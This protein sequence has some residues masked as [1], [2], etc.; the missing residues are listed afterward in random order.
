MLKKSQKGRV[1]LKLFIIILL[2]MVLSCIIFFFSY[3]KDNRFTAPGP[4]GQYGV[5]IVSQ[6]DLKNNS[7]F[8]LTS[9]WEIYRDKLLT[10]EDFSS[11]L[12]LADEYIFIGQYGG[13]E[14]NNPQSNSPSPH[15]K[16][17][18]RLHIN[19]PEETHNYILKLPE[20]F[21][22]Y[23]LYIDG[24]L[25]ME[26]GDPDPET[27][28]PKTGNTKVTFSASGLTEL[29]MAVSDYSHFY[30]GMI[31]PPA[32]GISQSVDHLIDMRFFIRTI[33]LTISLVVGIVYFCVWILLKR[34]KS[35]SQ[36]LSFYYSL[37]C[38]CY[39][40]F[41]A[42]PIVK[43][44]YSGG[45]SWYTIERFSFP[46][47]LLLII[48][49]QSKLS[50]IKASI[51][52]FMVCL[53]AITCLWAICIPMNSNSSLSI[54]L[55][56][57]IWLTIYSCLTA[58]FLFTSSC[59]CAYKGSAYS[60]SMLS[61][62]VVFAVA[63]V[64]E[65]IF[66]LFEPIYIGW[67]SEISGGAMVFSMG[68]I[69][70]SEVSSQF[71]RKLNLEYEVDFI[72]RQLDFQ[73]K[74][75]ESITQDTQAVK[76]MRHDLRH[77]LV[78]LGQLANAADSSGIKQYIESLSSNLSATQYKDY[79]K[80]RTVNAIVAHYL[81]LAES[82]GITTEAKLN[83]PESIGIVSSMDLCIILGN[84]LENAIEACRKVENSYKFIRVASRI[85]EDTISIVVTNSFDGQWS[86]TSGSYL[87]RKKSWKEK[88]IGLSSANAICKKY[89]GL[90][91]YNI[92]EGVWKACALVHM[93]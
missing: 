40:L 57:S 90:T 73:R 88:G 1:S 6:E 45:M 22:A 41:I 49:I 33:T 68:A 53:S 76:S 63:L 65:R 28:T 66:P 80:N 91:T 12:Y 37:L 47:M 62:A 8:F 52:N 59:Y 36:I 64:M 87:S 51:T 55:A 89:R 2:S 35:H 3:Q 84:F 7:L 83:I 15:G 82:E 56:Y 14:K 48:L 78:A 13:F 17:T 70:A 93:S 69:M 81:A 27:Y 39:A 23:R 86:E 10:P 74:Q 71:R 38:V 30:S 79:C 61:S 50:G 58:A 67:F 21:S 46:F 34:N 19:L 43:T 11:G 25:A 54:F 60:K 75:Y 24:N 5:L 26:M 31:S 16:A 42:Y 9:G 44:L 29:V 92:N 72:S 20:I 4:Q 18:Y 85:E 77:H 32:F